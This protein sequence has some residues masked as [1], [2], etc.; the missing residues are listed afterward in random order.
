LLA[1]KLTQSEK[2]LLKKRIK[3]EHVNAHLKQY[4]RLAIRYDKY[5]NN[6][7]GFLHLA[8]IDIILKK[9]CQ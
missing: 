2:E 4:R 7:E 8:C 6:Y 3:V 5:S 9:S 1:L